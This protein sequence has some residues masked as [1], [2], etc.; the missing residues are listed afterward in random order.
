MMAITVV[1]HAKLS[2]AQTQ[3]TGTMRPI[4][5]GFFEPFSIA[6]DQFGNLFVADADTH[7]IS[8]I[9]AVD[10]VI[11]SSPMV[12]VL[13]RAPQNPWSIAVDKSGNVYFG[14]LGS[15][16]GSQN[17]TVTKIVA[18]NGAIPTSPSTVNIDVSIESPFGLA[19]DGLG[20]LF[21]AGGTTIYELI[22]QNG[23][24]QANP[25]ELTIG[26]NFSGARGVAVDSDGNLYVADSGNHAVKEVVAVNGSIPVNPTIVNLASN[27]CSPSGVALNS[28][29]DLYFSDYCNNAIYKIRRQNGIFPA[30][31]IAEL[32]M[33]GNGLAGVEDVAVS[34]QGNI[35][36]GVTTGYDSIPQ[37]FPSNIDQVPVGT[38]SAPVPLQFRFSQ[39]STIGTISVL[40][41]GAAAGEFSD[42]HQG[43]CTANTAYDA[44]AYATC[45]VD[46]E[47]RPITAGTHSGAVVLRDTSGNVI[48]TGFVEGTGVAPQLSFPNG[49]ETSLVSGLGVPS[50]VAVDSSGN[51]YV[52]DTGN[53]QV[54]KGEPSAEGY[55]WSVLS[56]SPLNSPH[57][58][59]VDGAGDLF[60]VDTGNNRVLKESP[61]GNGYTETVAV[62]PNSSYPPNVPVAVAVDGNGVLAV[63]S[64]SQIVNY[65]GSILIT[66]LA[67]GAGV[68]ID[69]HG[70]VYLANSVSGGSILKYSTASVH[71]TGLPTL[72]GQIPIS[73][74]TPH[75]V[76]VDS[77]G[78]VY[79]TAV[80]DN[81][82]SQVIKAVPNG[83]SYTE[84]IVATNGLNQPFALA[85]DTSGN[86][87]IA[88]TGNSQLVKI[89]VA[90]AP[91]VAFTSTP[92]GTVSA[93]SPK[94]VT[95]ANSGNAPLTFPI[96]A[97]GYNPVISTGFTLDDSVPNACQIIGSGFDTP[98]TLAPG[99]SCDLSISFDPPG[100][101]NWGGSLDLTDNTLN[102]YA[103]TYATQSI[104]L[105]GYGSRIAPQVTWTTP[106]P[107]TYGTPLSLAQLDA[108]ANVDGT[109]IYNPG[110]GAILTA[111]THTITVLFR[112]TDG[113]DYTNVYVSVQIV[114]NPSTSLITWPAPDAITYGTPL[115]PTQLNATAN[116]AGAFSYSPAAGTVLSIGTHTLTATFTPADATDYTTATASVPI[117]VNSAFTLSASPSS[118]TLASRSSTSSAITISHDATFA[119]QASL[120][121]SG[122][123]SGVSVSFSANPAT[124]A[125]VLTLS[126]GRRV[127]SGTY[128]LIVTGTYGSYSTST[129]IALT[130]GGSTSGGGGGGKGGG[131]KTHVR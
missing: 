71:T 125:S 101:G 114:V 96:P 90:D 119:G 28:S 123:P 1:G 102:A 130:I 25:M 13:Y 118:L 35:Y 83:D 54:R 80:M 45:T 39:S 58:L 5:S 128:T 72:I 77:M 22:A 100:G 52:S 124:S 47:F 121:I 40:S 6:T 127:S 81:G 20:N 48:G 23:S 56:T 82:T 2:I 117:T 36:A 64:S 59:A 67:N 120:S 105:S 9:V 104:A 85:T 89:D 51:L 16:S 131:G 17:Y 61:N 24:V 126:A 8:E 50:G 62:G 106:A 69:A 103:P 65:G 109:F 76:A 21:V 94:T 92:F 14:V 87:Y 88:D 29:G 108:T 10:G 44:G 18:V 60:I 12:R 53:N 55:S 110:A 116:M 33:S 75:A 15:G 46:V 42:S 34:G 84:S 97:T 86:I 68:A 41:Q 107:I 70:I 74:G 95:V 122:V 93:D 113:A 31:S 43:T 112:P 3:F 79:I 78:N 19:T 66:N 11:P 37:I 26:S 49:T 30:N 38:L 99:A 4:A 27:Y 129:P 7:N 115:S 63:T 91:A 57:G 111:G 98:G 32:V 73:G